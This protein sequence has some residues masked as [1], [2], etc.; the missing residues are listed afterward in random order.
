[1]HS[2]LTFSIMSDPD[3]NI[4]QSLEYD[5]YLLARKWIIELILSTDMGKHFEILGNFRMKMYS[6]KDFENIEC[7]LEALKI[8]IKSSDIGHAAKTTDSHMHWSLLISEE[9]FR[10]GDIEKESGKPVSMYCDRDTTIIPKSQIGFLKNIALPLYETLNSFLNSS[11]FESH[12]VEQIRSNIASWELEIK[13]G[14]QL[15]MKESQ[16]RTLLSVGEKASNSLQ[17]G[18]SA[19]ELI[20]NKSK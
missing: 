9:F 13:T 19:S 2:S 11:S 6:I 1:M 14:A 16:F 4:L 3:K 12:C 10:Q 15:T 18:K 7:K 20:V 5:Q 8:V 17:S